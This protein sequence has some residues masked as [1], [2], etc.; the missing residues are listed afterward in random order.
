MEPINVQVARAVGW[1][2]IQVTM[3]GWYGIPP[4]CTLDFRIPAFD[5]DYNATIPEIERRRWDI[6]YNGEDYGIWRDSETCYEMAGSGP[7]ILA[8]CCAAL[9]AE[10]E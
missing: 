8:A 1:T 7:T 2:S 3:H 6:I 10:G 4:G 5:S 9:I